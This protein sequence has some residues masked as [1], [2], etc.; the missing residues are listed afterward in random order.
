MHTCYVGMVRRDVNQET[1]NPGELVDALRLI[2]ERSLVDDS[3]LILVA[4][5]ADGVCSSII[6]TS[7]LKLEGIKYTI[8][9]VETYTDLESVLRSSMRESV[10]TVILLNC[11]AVVDLTRELVP[12]VVFIVIDSHRPIHLKNVCEPEWIL[13]LDDDIGRGAYFPMDA[14]MTAAQD[15]E[16]DQDDVLLDDD[17]LDDNERTNKRAKT[18]SEECRRI[19]REYYEGYYYASP[20]ALVLYTLAADLGYQTQQLLWL[21]CVGLASYLEMGF[22]SADT[23]RTLASEIDSTHMVAFENGLRFTEDLRLIMYRH[24]SL[25]QAMWHTPYVYAKL[26]LHRDHGHG[27]MQKL[28]V[29]AG[30]SPQNYNQSFSSMSH[31]ARNL[32]GGEKF[33]KKC[34]AFGMTELKHYQ[35]VRTVRMKD[36][37]RPSLMLNE[38]SASD[39]YY[40]ITAALRMKGFNYAIDVATHTAPL[41]DLQECISKA[42][43]IQRDICVQAKMILDKRDWRKTRAFRYCVIHKPTS[44]MFQTCPEAIRCLALFLTNVLHNASDLPF[45]ICVRA[46]DHFVCIGTDPQDTKSEFV[47][48]FRNACESTAVKIQLNSFDFALAHVPAAE[49]ETW[50]HALL[51]GS[52]L[53]QDDDDEDFENDVQDDPADDQ[54]DEDNDLENEPPE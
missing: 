26:E 15:A 42:L 37:D 49:F 36:E 22:F 21:G 27:T 47:F 51:G 19:L 34:T 45:L 11:G 5:E 31:S 54:D 9:S 1:G 28:L 7:V 16:F 17:D 32:I 52:Q 24:W 6:L 33:K 13:V 44:S 8:Q 40:M 12:D 3:V 2:R 53:D 20:S 38:L 46:G 48:R 23:F 10:R 4:N 39:A 29:F 14:I 41:P 50:T 30:I 25:F 35:F 18:N 43:E